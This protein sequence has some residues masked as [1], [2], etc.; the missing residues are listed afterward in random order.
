MKRS[1]LPTG[2]DIVVFDC[3]STLSAVEG[4]DLLAKKHGVKKSVEKLTHHAMNGN[5]SFR[6]ALAQR[7]DLVKPTR[8]DLL[9]LGN[10]YIKK[11]LPGVKKLMSSLK[12]AGKD[13]YIV[14]GG[15]EAA[16]RVFARHVG[17]EESHVFS[18]VL[19]FDNSGKYIGF[20]ATN[21]LSKNHGKRIMLKELSKM[22]K[23]LFIG[24]GVT[25]LEAKDVVDLF[26]GFGGVKIRDIVK[27]ESDVF[28]EDRTLQKIA[29][30]AFGQTAFDKR[31]K[32]LAK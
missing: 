15:F 30:I 7:L 21:P 9:W 23:T 12:K 28:I 1:I 3:D 2:Y 29:K 16:L 27:K 8:E 32:M 5:G 17:V 25:D 19:L 31:A 13:V 14:S 20:E 22:G 24:D 10:E 4:I 6:D 11:T 26:V 18:N